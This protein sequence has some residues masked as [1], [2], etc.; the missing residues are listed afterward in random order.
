MGRPQRRQPP[1]RPVGLAQPVLD[2]VATCAVHQAG[3]GLGD[4]R[5]IVG[6]DPLVDLS[7]ADD[8]LQVDAE[9]PRCVRAGIDHLA[10]GGAGLESHDGGGTGGEQ[11]LEKAAGVLQLGGPLL[12]R[13]LGEGTPPG[14][15]LHHDR[16]QY[17]GEQPDGQEDA[18]CELGEVADE[19]PSGGDHQRPAVRADREGDR[20]GV[21]RDRK[22]GFGGQEHLVGVGLAAGIDR[23]PKLAER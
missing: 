2:R 16:G 14:L 9:H 11:A 21:P 7:G 3:R 20:V 4:E 6:V 15:G 17:G 13:R 18:G 19:R 10:P 22:A 23:A 8:A 12:D 5:E 1:V